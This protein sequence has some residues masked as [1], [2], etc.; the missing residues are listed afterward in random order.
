MEFWTH[1][2]FFARA[3]WNSYDHSCP[4]GPIVRATECE[5][6]AEPVPVEKS[7]E[8]VRQVCD[9]LSNR[10]AFAG[11]HAHAYDSNPTYQKRA[12]VRLIADRHLRCH[13]KQLGKKACSFR[14][15]GMKNDKRLSR[16]IALQQYR[17]SRIEPRI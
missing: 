5:K 7:T 17:T 1:F 16:R 12:N 4:V 8:M 10:T 14:T 11:V 6:D 9:T 2:A 3:S 13:A 15:K